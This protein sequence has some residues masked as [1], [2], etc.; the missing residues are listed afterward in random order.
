MSTASS[1]PPQGP[2]SRPQNHALLAVVIGILVVLLLMLGFG[3]FVVSRFLSHTSIETI[4]HGAD[5]VVDIKSPLGH[6]HVNGDGQNAKVS[7]ESPFGD[8]KVV[9]NPD[10]SRL[11]MEVYPGAVRVLSDDD[12]PFRDSGVAP[13]FQSMHGVSFPNTGAEISLRGSGGE[14][15][16]NV[17]EFRT[18]APAQQVL[19]FYQQQLSRFGLVAQKWDGPTRTLK[20][21]LSK[22]NERYVAV[23]SGND[24]TH[25]VL[26]RVEGGSAAR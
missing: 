19:G 9:P 7:I 6:L 11:D 5:Q 4:G 25:F 18:T 21:E 26:V 12:S 1:P 24:G 3:V 17:A 14:L 22:A 15:L 13:D 8:V 16:V 23:R 2:S 20:V 10:L